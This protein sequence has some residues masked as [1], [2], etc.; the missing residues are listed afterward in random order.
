MVLLSIR[1]GV[2][3]IYYR[4]HEIDALEN[5]ICEPA[6]FRDSSVKG[7]TILLFGLRLT[8]SQWNVREERQSGSKALERGSFRYGKASLAQNRV[9]S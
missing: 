3:I 5:V 4:E 7:A 2:H 9:S 8:V 6:P 1:W